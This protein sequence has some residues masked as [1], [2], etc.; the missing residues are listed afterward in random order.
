MATDGDAHP[1]LL[2]AALPVLL[3]ELRC[4]QQGLSTDEARRRLEETGPNTLVTTH[5][6]GLLAAL[7][8][9]LTHPLALLL[10]LAA[11][12]AVTTQGLTLGIAI[13]AVIALNAAFALIQER[14]A[15][16]AVA[17]LSAYLP[18]QTHGDPRR[19]PAGRRRRRRRT[20]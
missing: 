17:A 2:L 15:E 12:L 3:A 18:A 11:V 9:Q 10:W 16:H 13:I 4:D 6:G 20:R 5:K 14:H 1:D 8:R 19:S 7:L